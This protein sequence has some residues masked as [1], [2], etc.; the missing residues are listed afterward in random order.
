[1]DWLSPS[2]PFIWSTLI[3]ALALTLVMWDIMRGTP[4]EVS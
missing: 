4:P 1:M 3:L 2:N